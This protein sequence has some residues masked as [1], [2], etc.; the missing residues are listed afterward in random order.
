MALCREHEVG[1]VQVEVGVFGEQEVQ[2]FERFS[3]HE[4]VHSILQLHRPHVL[5]RKFK[6]RWLVL[7]QSATLAWKERYLGFLDSAKK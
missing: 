1:D 7:W 5:R 4:A 6:I 3:Q 2:V